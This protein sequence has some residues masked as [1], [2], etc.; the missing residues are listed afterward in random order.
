MNIEQTLEAR[1]WRLGLIAPFKLSLQCLLCILSACFTLCW[2]SHSSLTSFCCDLPNHVLQRII[3]CVAGLLQRLN[4]ICV[5]GLP[6]WKKLHFHGVIYKTFTLKHIKVY[7]RDDL[8][9]LFPSTHSSMQDRRIPLRPNVIQ[10]LRTVATSLWAIFQ[11]NSLLCGESE[12]PVFV[13]QCGKDKQMVR[14]GLGRSR[15]RQLFMKW[16][17]FGWSGQQ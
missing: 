5:C 2:C 13:S 14:R 17:H 15:E 9:R 12:G 11:P 10:L 6:L 3:E 8:Q 16:S 1:R 4:I 7:T